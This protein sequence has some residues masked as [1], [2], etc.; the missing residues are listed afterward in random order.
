MVTP[1]VM[2][3]NPRAAEYCGAF[4]KSM[5]AGPQGAMAPMVA[6]WKSA[7]RPPGGVRFGREHT[8][9]YGNTVVPKTLAYE[10]LTKHT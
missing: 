8:F 10:L 5:R 3:P 1:T 4:G 2:T 7:G 6:V 9:P